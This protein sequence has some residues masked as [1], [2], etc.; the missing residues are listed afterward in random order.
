MKIVFLTAAATTLFSLA[1]VAQAASGDATK[2][3]LVFAQCMACHKLDSSGVSTLG[4]N[5]Y[6][7]VNRPI[8][9]VKTFKYSPALMQK[10]GNWTPALLDAYLASPA[11]AIPGNRMP[12]AG[13]AKAEDRKNL[14]AYI[15][16]SSK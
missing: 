11:K 8:A 9:S 13:L 2:G 12:F 14:I 1:S 10:K 7:L 15:I 3:K 16:A 4:P 6:R 5:L